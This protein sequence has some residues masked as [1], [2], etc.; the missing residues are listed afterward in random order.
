MPEDDF[1]T[2]KLWIDKGYEL[3]PSYPWL[4]E[5][6]N[7]AIWCLLLHAVN[8]LESEPDQT[9][10]WLTSGLRS[11][12][13]SHIGL[14]APEAADIE[15]IRRLSGIRPA[16]AI[17]G[18]QQHF[19]ADMASDVLGLLRHTIWCQSDLRYIKAMV[20]Y[21]RNPETDGLERL[22]PRRT[23]RNIIYSVKMRL[24]SRI[25]RAL[26]IIHGQL[27]WYREPASLRGNNTYLVIVDEVHGDTNAG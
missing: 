20:M 5:S 15:R 27:L 18:E 26:T 4:K 25:F 14:T 12:G 19:D 21:A 11:G 24:T 2:A 7:N 6:R 9:I 13:W 10:S 22:F 1:D 23:K 17:R 8:V 16:E 3:L